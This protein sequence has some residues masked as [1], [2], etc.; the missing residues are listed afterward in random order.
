LLATLVLLVWPA[1]S[2]HESTT[3]HAICPEHG[4]RLDVT[5]TDAPSGSADAHDADGAGNDAEGA[6]EEC[7]FVLL[8]QPTSSDCGAPQWRAEPLEVRTHV[9][10]VAHE[11]HRSTPLL[12]LAPKQSP[13][14]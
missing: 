6:H 12:L 8:A 5:S 1:V 3:V 9:T 7:P 14:V 2:W 10:S 11:A 4:E 13:P